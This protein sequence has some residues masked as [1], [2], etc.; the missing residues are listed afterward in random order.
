M[1]EGAI[2][3]SILGAAFAL[4]NNKGSSLFGRRKQLKPMCIEMLMCLIGETADIVTRIVS[5]HSRKQILYLPEIF[6][7]VV[8]AEG[9]L[10]V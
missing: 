8:S 2:R 7:G 10:N 5:C 6:S 4:C 1:L 3:C 9:I